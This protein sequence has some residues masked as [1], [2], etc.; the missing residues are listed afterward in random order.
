[1]TQDA[2]DKE[3]KSLPRPDV[4]HFRGSPVMMDEDVARL[5]GIETR[6]LNEQVRRNAERFGGD[7]AFK[8]SSEEF[9]H[10][11]S[12]F[13]TSSWGGR[14][15]PPTV[16]TEHGVVMAAT[17]LRSERAAL[18]SRYIVEVFVEAR[19]TSLARS[20]GTN[21]EPSVPDPKKA[22]RTLGGSDL[23]KQLDVALGKVINA[24]GESDLGL[25]VQKE[26]AAIA[27]KGLAALKAKLDQPGLQNEKLNAEIGKLLA[28]A[29]AQEAL[30]GGRKIDNQHRR[31][32]LIAKQLRLIIELHRYVEKGDIDLLLAVLKDIGDAR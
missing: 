27:T 8:L 3:L 22:L 25:A 15:K 32:A 26:S 23:G 11:K 5:F 19:R 4:H 20:R 9:A 16:F 14:R 6:R 1:M 10:L 31:L 2:S 24:L 21:A 18:A 28:D 30:I 13:A 17:V 12:Q 7:F 29:E